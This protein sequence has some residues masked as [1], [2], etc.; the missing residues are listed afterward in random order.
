M[1]IFTGSAVALVTPFLPDGQVDWAAFEDLVYFHLENET[2][3]LVI[4]GTTGEVSTL[5]DQ[6]QI[7]LIRRA[8]EIV[9]G[10]I[11]VIAGTG[12]NDT[13]HSIYLSQEAE[14][15]GADA[16]LIV[17][18]YY[19]KGN[20][21]GLMRHFTSI[22][23]AVQIPIILYDVPSRTGVGLSVEQVVALASH[24]N[25]V[26]IKDAKGDM[27]HTKTLAQ[28]LNLDEFAIYSGNDDLIVPLMEAGGKG[29]ISVLAN[30]APRETHCMTQAVLEG[31][32]EE[33][34]KMQGDWNA[35]IESLFLEVN[36]IPV[37][38]G[39]YLLNRLNNVYRLPLW[40]P[41]DF[42]KNRLQQEIAAVG[43]YQKEGEIQ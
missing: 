9:K 14:K 11:P 43:H 30:V 8:V 3:A 27:D 31:R 2:D 37:K 12:I 24:P 42:V 17:T 22:A 26:A 41:S 25:I 34:R 36:P 4:T 19:N 16:L 23:D 20:H 35:L 13:Q 40:E 29:V 7:D 6:E 38:Y 1:T 33:A 5:S 39:L 32:I 10:Q 18:P 21:Q 28:A 15:V